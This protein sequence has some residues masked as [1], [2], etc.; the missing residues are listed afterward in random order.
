MTMRT[1]NENAKE[2]KPGTKGEVIACSILHSS[3]CI[4]AFPFLNPRC[5]MAYQFD[6]GALT[7]LTRG[8]TPCC[9]TIFPAGW[10]AI[11]PPARALRRHPS[12]ATS[13]S[14]APLGSRPGGGSSPAAS[15][16][17]GRAGGWVRRH[18]RGRPVRFDRGAWAWPSLRFTRLPLCPRWA[19]R[20]RDE[21]RPPPQTAPLPART[22]RWKKLT[23]A[24]Q[25]TT[26]VRS[27][28]RKPQR[29]HTANRRPAALRKGAQAVRAGSDP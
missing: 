5:V 27:C 24:S 7:T 12:S 20:H 10:T 8:S 1:Q 9:A 11:P 15:P 6:P 21:H 23:C 19:R 26:A 13:A 4:S 28:R 3:F 17:S 18:C 29:P 25:T 22:V 14:P 16:L 2:S